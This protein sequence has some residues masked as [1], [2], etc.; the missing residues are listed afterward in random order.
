MQKKQYVRLG[1]KDNKI[2]NRKHQMYKSEPQNCRI[3]NF[4]IR[5]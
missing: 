1:L 2:P 3:S 5:F 4:D